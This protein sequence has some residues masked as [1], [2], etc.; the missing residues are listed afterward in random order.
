MEDGRERWRYAPD[1]EEATTFYAPPAVDTEKGTLY[2]GSY[3]G[4][5]VALDADSGT[6]TWQRQVSSGRVIGGPALA[7]ELLIVPATDRQ[8]HAIR[9]TNGM[10]VWS[11]ASDRPFWSTPLVEGDRVYLAALDHHLYAL[12]TES[13]ELLWERDLSGALADRPVSFNGALLVGSFSEEL[14]AVDEESGRVEWSVATEDWVWG[15]PAV[16][17]GTAYF[18]DVSG[19]FFAVDE[20]G[21]IRWQL[22]LE[23]AVAASPAYRDGRLYFVTEGGGVFAR[24]GAS[25]DP[26]WEQTQEGRLLSDP[27]VTDGD[28]VLVAALDGENLLTAYHADSGAI[29]WTYQPAED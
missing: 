20:Q 18:G 9:T 6:I 24:E 3:D 2:A 28:L 13:G 12:N 23:S 1:E 10:E 21:G 4:H 29:R 7:G 17:D 22:S 27:I 14:N 11:F 19:E 8:L 5:I 25:N 26:L 15:N 16:G